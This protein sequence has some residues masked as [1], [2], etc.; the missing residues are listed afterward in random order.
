MT[1]TWRSSAGIGLVLIWGLLLAGTGQAAYPDKPIKLIIPWAA[2]GDTDALKRVAA[3][4]MEKPL[5]KPVVV[6][7]ITGA[8]GTTGLREFKKAAPDGYTIYSVHDSI[9]TTYYVG[10]SDLNYG[11]FEPICLLTSTPSVIATHARSKFNTMK[12]VLEE[13]RRRP[14]T[15]TFGATL[16]STSHFFPAMV[17]HDVKAKLWKYVSYEGTAPRMTALIG[18]HIELAETNIPG[19]KE[20]LKAGKMKLLAIATEKRHPALPDVPTLKELGINVTYAVNRGL[21]APKGTPEEALQKLEAACGTVAK[22]RG[23]AEAMEKMGS[24]VVFLN[25]KAYAEFLKKNDVLN[26]EVAKALGFRRKGSR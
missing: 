16:G 11:D 9:H 15:I 26:A 19:G 12:E 14:G 7:N 22:D 21:I 1:T 8:S 24:D 17:E 20:Q 4:A 5:G 23:F 3:N 25:R 13:A 6:V 10:V 18:G 2:G